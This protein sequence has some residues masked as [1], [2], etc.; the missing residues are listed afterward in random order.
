MPTF[1]HVLEG[2]NFVKKVPKKIYNS[3]SPVIDGSQRMKMRQIMIIVI[4]HNMN[5]DEYVT[6]I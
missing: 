2:E 5:T 1:V 6:T 3:I 4:I